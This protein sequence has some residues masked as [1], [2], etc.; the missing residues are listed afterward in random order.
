MF[1]M[2]SATI[3]ISSTSKKR[4][5]EKVLDLS[6]TFLTIHVD[7]ENYETQLEGYYFKSPQKLHKRRIY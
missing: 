1:R 3:G 7:P 5:R 4:K 2:R 6:L